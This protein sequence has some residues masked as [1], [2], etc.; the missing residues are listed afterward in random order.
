MWGDANEDGAVDVSD[1]VLVARFVAED[2]TANLK[3]QG[4]LNANVAGGA[5]LNADC[6]LKILRYIAKL[7]TAEELAPPQASQTAPKD[8]F[9]VN[10]Y[11]ERDNSKN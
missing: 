6:T 7:I 5:A 11:L 9:Q 8:Y 2:A 1:A 4:K 3:A 10:L